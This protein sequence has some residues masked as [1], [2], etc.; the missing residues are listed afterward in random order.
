MLFSGVGTRFSSKFATV[1]IDSCTGTTP[2]AVFAQIETGV[3][4]S[5]SPL[6]CLVSLRLIYSE[7]QEGRPVRIP[8]IA[9]APLALPKRSPGSAAAPSAPGQSGEARRSA[10][11]SE[12]AKLGASG[13][14]LL[15]SYGT[16]SR[17]THDNR[18]IRSARPCLIAVSAIRLFYQ[19]F[20]G[21]LVPDIDDM[22]WKLR[23][24]ERSSSQRIHRPERLMSSV[25]GSDVQCQRLWPV[26]W[27]NQKRDMM[28][29]VIS[30]YPFLNQ[31]SAAFVT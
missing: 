1:S 22:V 9:C 21:P 17:G 27:Q 24:C 26:D 20:S 12:A 16:K 18:F 5:L 4:F 23:R 7:D 10:R 31:S 8:S 29:F 6:N 3:F 15:C 19:V 28:A 14:T 2:T 11:W 13:A 30:L 25:N